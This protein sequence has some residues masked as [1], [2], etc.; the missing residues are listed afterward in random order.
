MLSFSA[1]LLVTALATSASDLP[2]VTLMPL[3]AEGDV[4]QATAEG[5]TVFMRNALERAEEGVSEAPF[6]D[7]L[8]EGKG[9][10]K[11]AR[12]CKLKD[13]CLTKLMQQRGSDL[14]AAGVVRT[15]E[16]G[17][18][19]IDLMVL[20]PGE[21][22]VRRFK[23]PIR[24]D[25]DAM[26]LVFDRLIRKAYA[27]QTLAGAL[28]ITGQPEGA[29]ILV[30][31][32]RAGTLPLDGPLLGISEGL[33]TVSARLNGYVTLEKPVRVRFRETTEVEL[34]LAKVKAFNRKSDVEASASSFTGVNI[35]G[36]STLGGAAVAVAFA[37]LASGGGALWQAL[38][39]DRRADAQQLIF[40]RD[41]L[42]IRSGQGLAVLSNV[43]YGL[44]FA[45]A[46]GA[47]GWVATVFAADLLLAPN[48]A[49]IE[50]PAVGAPTLDDDDGD[51]DR[52]APLFEAPEEEDDDD[53]DD[54]PEELPDGDGRPR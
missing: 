18:L 24:G 11:R 19:E 52:P 10:P 2:K 39:V 9:D 5:M 29:E 13:K 27:P 51:D 42:L 3:Q 14:L 34:I 47:G 20:A 7:L 8:P 12:K 1:A 23:M 4:D 36:P 22:V 38:E 32:R 21:G 53:D 50:G 40:P 30:D 46:V 48:E 6:L 15:S 31:Q 37:G 54:A 26:A 45:M 25:A 41:T 35:W 33:H 28:L 43:L 17:G 16:D 44:A 49:A